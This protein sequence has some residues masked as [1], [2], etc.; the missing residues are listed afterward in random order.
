MEALRQSD[1]MHRQIAWLGFYELN[2]SRKIV[3]LARAGGIL[4]DVGANAGYFTCLWAGL[5]GS[6]RV[7]AFEPSP[8]VCS[9]LRRNIDVNGVQDRVKVFD[10]ALGYES[11]T[12][13]FDPCSEKESGWGGLVTRTSPDVLL[14]NVHRL[15]EM[16]SADIVVDVLKIDT[17]GADTWV[18]F[19]AER[20]LRAKRI[21]HVFFE[22]NESR[23]SQLGIKPGEAERFL[24]DCG[25]RVS[26][27]AAS[28]D[29]ELWATCVKL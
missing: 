5:G 13:M 29:G 2:L 27:L 22:R 14:V 28:T 19:G 15:D 12:A 7:Y 16:L 10:L 1:S 24:S 21:K 4:V 6:N 11:G 9:M 3:G 18:L 20:L 25:Y 17:E 26:N 23:M 8:D